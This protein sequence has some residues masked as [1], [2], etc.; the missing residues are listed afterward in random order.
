MAL[1]VPRSRRARALAVTAAAAVVLPIAAAAPAAAQSTSTSSTGATSASALRLTLNLPAALPINPVVLDIDPVSGTVRAVP[2]SSPEARAFA[3]VL[4]GS[5]G[6][7]GQSLGAAEATL[8][9]PKEAVGAPLAQLN[10]GINGSPLSTF[11][12]ISLADSRAAVTEAPTSTSSAGTQIAVGLPP[13]LLPVLTAVLDPLLAGVGQAIDAAAAQLGVATSQLCAGLAPITGPVSDGVAA[14]PGIGLLLEDIVDGVTEPEAGTLCLLGEFLVELKDELTAS[15]SDLIGPGGLLETGLI[16]ASQSI[17][18]EG[19]TTTSTST[20]RV[21]GFELL[22]QNPFGT[23]TVLTTTST[24]K[25]GPGVAEATVDR[26]AVEAFARPLLTLET[27]LQTVVGDLAGIDL[28][29]LDQVLAAVTQVLDALAGIGVEAGPLD[30]A[31]TAIEGCPTALTPTLTGTFEEP[32]VCAAA[33]A[34]GFGLAV[35]LPAQLAGPLGIQGPL[36]QL[37]FAPTAA[38]AGSAPAP[39]AAPPAPAPGP[40]P[41]TGPEALLAAAGLVLLAGAGLLRRRRALAAL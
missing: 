37:T 40:L 38:V 31:D 8:P 39:V 4:S 27:D 13:Q 12:Q 22:G 6:S 10:D 35:T 26:T 16:E 9:T 30:R 5:V 34:R 23:G 24:A 41:R 11:L 29:G 20:S 19:S 36:V 15:L 32:G 14:V 2:G 17:V 18:V 7:Q 28:S 21:A 33:A 3:A 25:V 1:T